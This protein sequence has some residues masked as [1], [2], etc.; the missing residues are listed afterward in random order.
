MPCFWRWA[1][2]WVFYARGAFDEKA[3]QLVT[4]LLMAYGIGMPAYLGRDVLVRVFYALGDGTTPFRLSVI[5]IGL[6][7]VF[8]WT[9]VGG[10]TPWGPQLTINFGAAGLVL[11]TVLINVL[12]CLAL[13][14]ALQHRLQVL[15]LKRWALDSAQLT[16]A[17]ACAGIGAWG[18]SQAISWP[19]DLLGR[20]LQVGLSAAIGLLLFIVIGQ[21]FAVQEVR[22]ISKILTRRLSRR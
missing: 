16:V 11:A 9:L 7:V 20:L 18:L 2:I 10:P 6:N 1:L 15:P 3:V 17:A 14:L 19:S 5:G 21:A 4:S 12:T 13:L 8:D 22:D